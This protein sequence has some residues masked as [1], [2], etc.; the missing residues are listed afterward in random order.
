MSSNN[1]EV[2]REVFD[3]LQDAIRSV[4]MQLAAMAVLKGLLTRNGVYFERPA[5]VQ[6]VHGYV[7]VSSPT[8]MAPNE[9]VDVVEIA[10]DLA[11]QLT[12]TVQERMQS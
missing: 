6:K 9:K 10:C 5:G 11:E 12:R 2:E 8:K 1:D 4:D 3:G 7:L